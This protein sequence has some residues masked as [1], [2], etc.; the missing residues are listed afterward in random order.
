MK[1]KN[2]C[3]Q[4]RYINH[5]LSHK[6]PFTFIW[7]GIKDFKF[8][9]CRLW[10]GFAVVGSCYKRLCF[11]I[12]FCAAFWIQGGSKFSQ[13]KPDTF[14]TVLAPPSQARELTQVWF[15]YNVKIQS[16]LFR[17]ERW[18]QNINAIVNGSSVNT[19]N[20]FNQTF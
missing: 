18:W 8:T 17:N 2:V 14:N 9:T 15:F 7:N 16:N 19:V 10:P 6:I 12:V 11:V 13:V 1:K 4:L 5:F 20:L 3:E